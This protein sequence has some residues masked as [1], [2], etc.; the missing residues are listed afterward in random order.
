M[1]E[2]FQI[3][4]DDV[5]FEPYIVGDKRK[6]PVFDARFLGRIR[7]KTSFIRELHAMGYVAHIVL[8]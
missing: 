7:N 8:T 1:P 2:C 5:K 6:M 4:V 3:I